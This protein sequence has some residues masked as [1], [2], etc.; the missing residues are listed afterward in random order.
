M[1]ARHFG[2]GREL[3]GRY[4]WFI[5]NSDDR[6]AHCGR[7]RPNDLGLFDGLGN[8][9]ELTHGEISR[10]SQR[11][12]DIDFQDGELVLTEQLNFAI[13]GGGYNY[14][15]IYLRSAFRIE[16]VRPGGNSASVGFRP[17]R[18]LP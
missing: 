10:R 7:L 12:D 14:A 5:E 15:A 13:R 8:V 18:T 1:T 6:N 4:G 11:L 17:V 16:D 2:K 3:L 9:A